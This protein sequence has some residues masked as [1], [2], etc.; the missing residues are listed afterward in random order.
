MSLIDA[1]VQWLPT[2]LWWLF[3][4]ELLG[5]LVFPIVSRVA[6]SLKDKGF[7]IS[8][9]IA[10]VLVTYISWLL[11]FATGY[12]TLTVL[13]SLMILLVSSAFII[14]RH[15]MPQI[16]TRFLL[17]TEIVFL[18]VFLI[19]LSLH[20]YHPY[21]EGTVT[22]TL[23]TG[24]RFMDHGFAKAVSRSSSFP[25]ADPWLSGYTLQHYYYF[26]FSISSAL[27]AISQIPMNIMFNLWN[28]TITALAA[29]MAFGFSYMLT[30]RK[31]YALFTVLFFVFFGNLYSAKLVLEKYGE[32]NLLESIKSYDHYYYWD[33]TRS[34]TGD[35]VTINEF[36]FFT[37]IWGDLH[38]HFV[39]FPFQILAIILLYNFI[40]SG[41]KGFGIFGKNRRHIALSI[42]VFGA[43]LGIL[44][45]I[46]SWD[47]PTYFALS[48]MAIFLFNH[49]NKTGIKENVLSAAAPLAASVLLYLPYYL[50]LK[51]Q[52]I[53]GVAVTSYPSPLSNIL[54][55][56]GFP[57]LIFYS[58]LIM[59]EKWET[60]KELMRKQILLSVIFAAALGF[61]FSKFITTLVIAP[62][63]FLSGITILGNMQNKK[64][65]K[66][67]FF[68]LLLILMLSSVLTFTS[69]FYLNS[70]FSG[71]NAERMNTVFKMN[72]Q[73]WIMAGLVAGYALQQ[74]F[75]KLKQWNPAT[76][77]IW[78]A[79]FVMLLAI[80]SIYPFIGTYTYFKG[81]GA[82]PTLDGF[83]YMKER[84]IEVV[85][86]GD[87][88][89][90]VKIEP[91]YYAVKWIDEN[92][93]GTP[94]MLEAVPAK[95]PWS[96]PFDYT[97]FSRIASLT[98]VPTLIGWVFHE[99]NWGYETDVTEQRIWDTTEI[100]TTNDTERAM[101]LLAKYNV[102]YVYIGV[103]E[104]LQYPEEGLK[105]FE[106]IGEKVYD[107]K[108][109]K[110]FEIK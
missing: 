52:R 97:Y 56:F 14:R 24:E 46:N 75:N 73:A 107:Y 90:R 54:I 18:A 42:A 17:K 6:S 37:S 60:V 16:D 104:N 64:F 58:F 34:L 91:D 101:E 92:I 29:S 8:K 102:S 57:L 19:F 84:D 74:I 110:I 36:P 80:S 41:R 89:V 55:I 11:S 71:G 77:K 43:S 48:F 38:A 62:L 96:Q 4:I 3:V 35:A 61:L 40:M 44:F 66:G 53:S 98:G 106:D 21:I 87:R 15:G 63:I 95:A 68:V 83:E 20:M 23:Y 28:S 5:L 9:A 99:Y 25:P 88:H 81:F 69:V 7:F 76:K 67:H 26:G 109:A 108:G 86:E 70:N 51:T 39:S 33:P 59:A 22:D 2:I 105:K 47:Y 100:Y 103:L 27:S 30:G 72:L 13:V 10:I 94:T 1:Y 12:S 78:L 49:M 85:L 82:T 93:Q 32:G 50:S 65:Q 45:P 31:R 79:A